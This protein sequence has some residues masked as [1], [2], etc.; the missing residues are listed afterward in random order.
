MINKITLRSHQKLRILTPVEYFNTPLDNLKVISGFKT[1]R[2]C[3][4]SVGYLIV[5]RPVLWSSQWARDK[6]TQRCFLSISLQDGS[7]NDVVCHYTYL[8]LVWAFG[9]LD[10][11]FFFR[12]LPAD[13]MAEERK[14]QTVNTLFGFKMSRSSGRWRNSAKFTHWQS[15][16]KLSDFVIVHLTVMINTRTLF[17]IPIII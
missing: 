1:S 2:D 14:H 13:S 6:Q 7:S 8:D 3:W 12:S 4:S 17:I 15:F 11:F 5:C 9:D 10:C 16:N